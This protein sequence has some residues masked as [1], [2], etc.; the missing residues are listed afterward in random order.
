MLSATIDAPHKFAEWCENRYPNTADRKSVVLATTNHRIVPLTHYG[1]LTTNE[2]HI[3]AIKDKT[4]AKEVRDTTNKLILLQDATGKFNDAGQIEIA[5]TL[6]LFKVR[7]IYNKRSPILNNLVRFLKDHDMLPAIAFVFS[8]KQVE[9][10][11]REIQVPLLED[12]SKVPYTVK[13]ECDQIIRRLPNFQE[14]Q[15][16]PEYCELVALLEK[17]VAIHHSGMIPILREIVELM[18]SKK[19]VKLLFA[20]ESFAIGL[21]CPIKTAVFTSLTKFD[22]RHERTLYSHEYTQMAGRAG[23][24]GIDT[25]G[26]VVHCNNLFPPP[27]MGEYKTVLGGKPQTLVSKFKISYSLVLSLAKTKPVFSKKDACDFVRKSMITAELNSARSQTEI[28]IAVLQSQIEKKAQT[29]RLLKSPME[30]ITEYNDLAKTVRSLTNKKRK[31]AERRIADLG[32]THRTIKSDT[33]IYEELMDLQRC[34]ETETERLGE[35]EGFVETQV[36]KIFGVLGENGYIKESADPQENLGDSAESKET[37]QWTDLGKIASMVAEV[38]PLIITNFYEKWEHFRDFSPTQ[39]VG[40]LSAFCDV[41]VPED[42]ASTH[43]MSADP[44]LNARINAVAAKYEEYD[45]TELNRDIITGIHYQGALKYDLI[46]LSMEW[47]TIQTEEEAKLFI[48]DSVHALQIS[49][50]DFTKAMMK[51]STIAKELST[52]MEATNDVEML[53]RA[54]TIDSMI[55]KYITTSQSLYV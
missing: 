29:L 10:C 45:I 21:D 46:D 31:D 36:S 48:R 33:V 38:H 42:Q 50:G 12:D 49:T 54:S 23:R 53:H 17:G 52:V 22:G 18:I 28:Q 37:Y 8:R 9:V 7:Q 15:S 34:L 40:F 30:S 47:T 24:R 27:T 41:K 16:L 11:A 14:Y 2:S 3:K 6:Q 20:T 51:I 25:I 26:H 19:Y 44:L 55:L 13:R 5:K 4:L 1:F 35:I 39:L 43:A 32:E